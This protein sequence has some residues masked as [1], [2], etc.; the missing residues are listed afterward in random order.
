MK[1]VNLNTESEAQDFISFLEKHEIDFE[2]QRFRDSS[3]IAPY[4]NKPR[5]RFKYWGQVR[6]ENEEGE[7][8]EKLLVSHLLDHSNDN[9]WGGSKQ[10]KRKNDFDF[11]KAILFLLCLGLGF[12]CAKFWQANKRMSTVK[13]YDY[14]WSAD[15]TTLLCKLKSNEKVITRFFDKNFDGNNEKIEV[16][17]TGGI[18]VSEQIDKDEDGLFEG[19]KMFDVNQKEI[20]NGFD[21][22]ADGF[23]EEWNYFLENGIRLKLK[24]ENNNG[25]YELKNV[26]NLKNWLNKQ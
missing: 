7:R 23:Y 8:L 14:V 22:N 18:K 1:E 9:N 4:E 26:N 17:S 13:N 20:G 16:Y 5:E 6:L 19:Y 24:D 11:V 25:A 15:G 12:F 21:R 2:L 3:V 10:M